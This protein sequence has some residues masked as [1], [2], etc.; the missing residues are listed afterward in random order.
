MANPYGMVM[1]L[2]GRWEYDPKEYT[3]SVTNARFRTP[4]PF[5]GVGSMAAG[6]MTQSADAGRG[7]D[8][9][10]IR[11]PGGAPAWGAG[12]G[13]SPRYSPSFSTEAISGVSPSEYLGS[14][15]RG[16][17][18]G[19]LPSGPGIGGGTMVDPTWSSTGALGPPE[20]T[21]D[22]G[23]AA[24]IMSAATPA[25]LIGGG[26]A[27]GMG[28]GA[29]GGYLGRAAKIGKDFTGRSIPG[30]ATTATEYAA[31]KAATKAGD[32]ARLA[33][34]KYGFP[35]ASRGTGLKGKIA[36]TLTKDWDV[37]SSA[38]KLTASIFDSDKKAVMSA[39]AKELYGV[40]T[41]ATR[42][43]ALAQLK[44]ELPDH[45]LST[46]AKVSD[47]LS[48]MLKSTAVGKP[49]HIYS[50]NVPGPHATSADAAA[51][52][53][54]DKLGKS[55]YGSV[56]SKVG[57][58]A[59]IGGT[60]G[61]IAGGIYGKEAEAVDDF[62]DFQTNPSG[63]AE[64]QGP[65]GGPQYGLSMTGPVEVSPFLSIGN[66]PSIGY[67]DPR[68]DKNINVANTIQEALARADEAIAG[69]GLTGAAAEK[70]SALASAE[71][72]YLSA[73]QLAGLQ[74]AQQEQEQVEQ[75]F[76]A[77]QAALAQA[78]AA[79]Q[80]LAA[81]AAVEDFSDY[82]SQGDY[83]GAGGSVVSGPAGAP[84]GA[85]HAGSAA[86][87]AVDRAVDRAVQNAVIDALVNAV[88][89]YGSALSADYADKLGYGGAF[90]AGG[91]GG[92]GLGDNMGGFG[93]GW[94]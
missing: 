16:T 74:A 33:A 41:A 69:M 45:D 28:L 32:E 42:A 71:M 38:G 50:R 39:V 44:S 46:A 65:T 27:A 72:G 82:P 89:P 92:E 87:K 85:H 10:G 58:G 37:K 90:A 76:A 91:T 4:F 22:P 9:P 30:T 67:K 14:I 64:F 55:M 54:M 26:A 83:F 15:E 24:M 13:A 56:P 47:Y 66:A 52:A 93:S 29:I 60:V 59:A 94:T 6:A 34:G 12:L 48:A 53:A 17:A 51:R 78:Y 35:V 25:G 63:Y 3:R 86:S 8:I 61:G 18:I 21:I 77:E 31:A 7:S 49:S 68:A 75:A 11:G 23:T 1:G 20:H 84:Q 36:E 57:R 5:T 81:A 73:D 19:G 2:D 62:S 40:S 88:D 79:D 70:A 43:K 80:S